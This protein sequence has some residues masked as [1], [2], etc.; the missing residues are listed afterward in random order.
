MGSPGS[1]EPPDQGLQDVK[2]SRKSASMTH[3]VDIKED[4]RVVIRLKADGTGVLCP[5]IGVESKYL[6]HS[7]ATVKLVLKRL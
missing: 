6:V 7:D 4:T 5:D 3:Q 1:I 2:D